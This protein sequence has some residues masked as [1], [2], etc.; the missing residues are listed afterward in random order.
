M[1]FS[2]KMLK[3]D[4]KCMF[5]I[6]LGVVMCTTAAC[7]PLYIPFHAQLINPYYGLICWSG[8]LYALR[9]GGRGR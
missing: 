4:Y 8:G 5:F 2:Y 6:M 1:K 9:Q 3:F 7:L